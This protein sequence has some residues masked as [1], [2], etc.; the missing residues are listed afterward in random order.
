ME[1]PSA[2]T[3][4]TMPIGTANTEVHVG[5][6][7]AEGL[8]KYKLT[9]VLTL[10]PRFLLKNRLDQAVYFREHG[11]PP[12]DLAP[13]QPG[14]RAPIFSLRSGQDKLMTL[15]YAGL[16][17]QWYMPQCCRAEELMTDCYLKD[18]PH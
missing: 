12:H 16:N 3:G 6:S 4:V 18:S 13:L 10:A 8:G 15:A 7:W 1:A 9:K 5:V 17:A 2:E 14:E 11:V